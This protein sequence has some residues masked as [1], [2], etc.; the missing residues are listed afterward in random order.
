M[1]KE[2][3]EE[4]MAVGTTINPLSVAVRKHIDQQNARSIKEAKESGIIN[5]TDERA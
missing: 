1:E 4:Y 5:E 3:Q 2:E